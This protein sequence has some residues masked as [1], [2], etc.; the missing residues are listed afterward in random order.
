LLRSPEPEDGAEPGGGARGPHRDAPNRAE[1]GGSRPRTVRAR[2]SRKGEFRRPPT[3]EGHRRGE[4]KSGSGLNFASQAKFGPDPDFS[5]SPRLTTSGVGGLRNSPFLHLRARTVLG[6]LPPPSARLGASRW[7][8]LAPPPGAASPSTAYR[9]TPHPASIQ[10]S[11]QEIP[12]RCQAVVP[13]AATDHGY[14][15]YEHIRNALNAGWVDC[16]RGVAGL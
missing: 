13:F 12:L 10:L 7:G 15:I 5:L 16:A 8:P 2:K 6:L 4:R 3:P 11:R 1:G 9:V 14:W